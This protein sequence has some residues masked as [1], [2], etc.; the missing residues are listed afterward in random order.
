MNVIIFPHQLYENHPGLKPGCKVFL[1]EDSLFFLDD[2]YPVNFHKQKLVL[3]K[4]SM[5]HYATLLKSKGF[6]VEV[7]SDYTFVKKL[8]KAS[9]CEVTDYILEKR[10][11]KW[12]IPITWLPDPGFLLKKETVIEELGEKKHYLMASFYISQRKRFNILVKNGKP[13]GEKWSFDS[14]NRK[15]LPAT[16]IP[17][18]LPQI[19]DTSVDI[20]KKWVD[21]HFKNNL[22]D[23]TNFNYPVTH[24]QAKLWLKD[25]LEK[26]FLNFGEYEDAIDKKYTHLFHSVLSSSLNIGLLTPAQVIQE[27]LKYTDKVP[28]NS[29]E[30]FI[31]QII[32][33]REFMRGIYL[34]KGVEQRNSNFFQHKHQLS[35][36]FYE[37]TTGIEPIDTTIKRL[38]QTA[39]THHIE[40]LMVMGNFMLL[41]EIEPHESYRWFMENYIDAYDWVMVPNVY[42]MS[43]YADGGMITTKP[44]FSGSN[45]IRKMSN[46]QTGHWCEIWDALFWR[47]IYRHKEFFLK[48]PRLSMMVK[49]LN[50]FSPSDF[51]NK[52]KIADRFI[53]KQSI[54]C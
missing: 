11:N 38:H 14:E 43:Q 29:L 5:D 37:G 40:R 31:R 23:L 33:W 13:I 3:H 28:I 27:A 8:D 36:H 18:P 47:F 50:K 26:R 51:Q 42:G 20:S 39:Y 22:G 7:V 24:S 1:V 45:Y 12:N 4:A 21:K 30:G 53:E 46:Y 52:V 6:L 35:K 16:L 49:N 19:K 54:A 34:V 41:L 9:I 10:I 17:P 25:F 15:K 32:G 2:Q 44:Y 48:N